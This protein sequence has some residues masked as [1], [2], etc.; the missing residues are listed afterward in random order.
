M[1]LKRSYEV[2]RMMAEMAVEVEVAYMFY[3]QTAWM[4]S[5]GLRPDTEASMLKLWVTE[6]SRHFADAAM[7]VLGPHGLLE[8]GSKWS[9]LNGLV[10]RGYLDSVS[11]TIGAGTSEIQRNIIAV[12]G[13]GL[14]RK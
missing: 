14:P 3:W 12:R 11:A 7:R 13:L 4:L 10:P 5:K 9:P 8:T 2:R 6:L 1:A